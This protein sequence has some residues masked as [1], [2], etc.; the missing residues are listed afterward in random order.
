MDVSINSSQVLLGIGEAFALCQRCSYVIFIKK[1]DQFF[2]LFLILR[3]DQ[4]TVIVDGYVDAMLFWQFLIE[5]VGD[6][7]HVGHCD[8][9]QHLV[10]LQQ[11]DFLRMI[12]SALSLKLA[13]SLKA[14][15]FVSA[16]ASRSVSVA[17]R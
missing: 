7:L 16:K 3:N 2:E 14:N 11:G 6:G 13:L 8:I 5:V 9:L 1:A 15:N 12:E 4:F 17:S 10:L